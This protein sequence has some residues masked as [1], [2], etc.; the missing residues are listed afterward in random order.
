MTSAFF[1]EKQTPLPSTL[2]RGVCFSFQATGSGTDSLLLS[3]HLNN[4]SYERGQI[5]RSPAGDQIAKPSRLLLWQDPGLET[6][7]LPGS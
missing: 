6:Q 5:I 4:G 1:F 7:L 3:G 2:D